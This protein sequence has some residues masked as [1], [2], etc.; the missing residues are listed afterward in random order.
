MPPFDASIFH[1]AHFRLFFFLALFFV[2][3]AYYFSRHFML[4][5]RAYVCLL[6][7]LFMMPPAYRYTYIAYFFAHRYADACRVAEAR[8]YWCCCC[9][10]FDAMPLRFSAMLLWLL[11]IAFACSARW[12]WCRWLSPCSRRRAMFCLL[13]DYC[14]LFFLISPVHIFILCARHVAYAAT[15]MFA[16]LILVATAALFWCHVWYFFAA[17]F[18]DI[19]TCHAFAD[20]PL[21]LSAEAPW[22]FVWCCRAWFHVAR[23]LR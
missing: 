21:L 15:I 1:Y 12:C 6:L 4:P 22:L 18:T 7:L 23:C 2:L 3:H 17:L 5:P 14:C 11:L 13:I 8:C 20:M 9:A 16:V 19:Y 10:M